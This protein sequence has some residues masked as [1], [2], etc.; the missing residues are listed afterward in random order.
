MPAA[1]P[2]RS[3]P[4]KTHQFIKGHSGFPRGRPK[5]AISTKA[6][7]RKVATKKHR[8]KIDGR[9]EF[10]TLLELVI[11][12]ANSMAMAGHAG[13]ADLVDNLRKTLQPD[14]AESGG[15]LVVPT[16]T[17]AEKAAMYKDWNERH[18]FEPGSKEQEKFE[19]QY[20]KTTIVDASC[21]LGIA[22]DEFEAKWLGWSAHSNYMTVTNKFIGT[23][24]NMVPAAEYYA[25]QIVSAG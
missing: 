13:A 16:C 1:K 2:E 18:P 22:M 14:P 19:A 11:L 9:V 17:E 5:G 4:P 21:P 20:Y 10:R 12:K 25:G 7:T 3:L 6:L 15:F 8:V 24:R 23:D